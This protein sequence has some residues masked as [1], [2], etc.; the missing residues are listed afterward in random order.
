MQSGIAMNERKLAP[1]LGF[2]LSWQA[3]HD[4]CQ[5]ILASQPP[6]HVVQGG[7]CFRCPQFDILYTTYDEPYAGRRFVLTRKAAHCRV[8]K[9]G[10]A[11][12]KPMSQ[13][14]GWCLSSPCCRHL[15]AD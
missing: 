8:G 1:R 12:G 11:K 13:A 9:P 4:T 2:A 5:M 6:L 10:L 15:V 3:R 14:A 7:W